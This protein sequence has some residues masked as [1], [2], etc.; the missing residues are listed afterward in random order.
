[1]LKFC[2]MD[3]NGFIAVIFIFLFVSNT[4]NASL[5]FH[6]RKLIASGPNNAS[7]TSQVSPTGSPV[8]ESNTTPMNAG[9]SQEKKQKESQMDN[10]TNNNRTLPIDSKGS[11][12]NDNDSKNSGAASP[13]A[14]EK[15]GSTVDKG[16][17]K[18]ANATTPKLGNN[19]SCEGSLTS[20]RDQEMLA[21][22]EASKEGSKE[23]FLVVQ[24]EGEITLKVNVNLPNYLKNDFPAFEVPKHETGRMDISS[25]VGKSTELIVNSGNAKC[26]LHL[27]HSVSVD[28]LIQQLSFYSKQV[29]PIYAVY[30]SFLLALLFGGTWA[31]CKLRKRNQQDGIPFQEL[32][33]GLPES[34]S[35]VNVDAAEGWD[36][37]WDDDWEEGSAVK[38]PAG[39]QVR[40]V[41]A[42]GLTSRSS[43]KDGWENDWDD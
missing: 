12:K 33:M 36:H 15:N 19:G 20:C 3:K 28:N 43:K 26:V 25:T 5:V 23:V 24:N 10:Q 42:D 1:M 13:P 14:G 34:A 38:S 22:I 16:N 29:T 39:H 32:E 40:S 11:N 6:L 2:G 8:N 4:C 27:V 37:D 17:G 21:C 9:K 41:S 30:A 7:T 31:C 35:A 18:A